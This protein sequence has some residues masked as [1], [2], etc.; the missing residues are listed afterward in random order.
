MEKS[1]SSERA[2]NAEWGESRARKVRQRLSEL[3]AATTL[4]D[5]ATLPGARCHELAGDL[6][7]CL[8]VDLDH[9]YRLIFAPA[10]TPLPKKADGGLDW[11]AVTA[12]EVCGIKDTH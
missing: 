7:G 11:S 10:H 6:E 1:C 5:V 4:A 8:S 9:P 12:I 3:R 2:M